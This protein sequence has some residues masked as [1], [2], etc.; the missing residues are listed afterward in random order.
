MTK[1]IDKGYAI[2]TWHQIFDTD[3]KAR[4]APQLVRQQFVHNTPWWEIPQQHLYVLRKC[5][6]NEHRKLYR[7]RTGGYRWLY[8]PSTMDQ[9][10][11]VAA[12]GMYMPTTT[13]YQDN[14]ST[15]LLVENSKLQAAREHN[16]WIFCMFSSQTRPK[17]GEVKVAFCTMHNMLGEFFTKALQGTLFTWMR[18]R[19]L[20]VPGCKMQVCKEVCWRIEK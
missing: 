2:P 17:K 16:I 18:E 4:W 13:I 3:N 5:K 7:S 11:L 1:K 6:Q 12:Q 15:N 19:I 9:T 20:N 10:F 8:G 14:K